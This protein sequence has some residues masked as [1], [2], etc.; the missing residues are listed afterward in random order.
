MA[1]NNHKESEESK[2]FLDNLTDFLG[3]SEEQTKEEVI[4]ELRDKG[5][6]IDSIISNC[7]IMINEKI[8]EAKRQWLIDAPTLRNQ[9]QKQ[10]E[11][12]Q[13]G[14]PEDVTTLKLKIKEMMESGEYREQAVACFRNFHKMTDDD[15]RNLYK[16]FVILID[17]KKN[18]AQDNE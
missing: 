10:I 16:D 13:E 2:I 6:D 8:G 9:M 18:E 12:Y 14:M 7:K 4:T 3:D 11:S 17:L 1:S 15:L 5:I